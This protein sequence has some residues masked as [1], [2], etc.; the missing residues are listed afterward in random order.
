MNTTAIFEIPPMKRIGSFFLFILLMLTIALPVHA[1]GGGGAPAKSP[2]MEAI[3]GASL[4]ELPEKLTELDLD[5]DGYLSLD[6]LGVPSVVQ[7]LVGGKSPADVASYLAEFDAD[8]DGILS[9][10]EL[11][12]SQ[13]SGDV[14][15]LWLCVAY[16]LVAL[17]FSSRCSVAE[18]VLLSISPSYVANLEKE[19]KPSATHHSGFVA[20]RLMWT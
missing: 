13:G 7:K 17:L 14:R 2:L 3:E 19:G 9:T 12:G 10:A 18:A 11:G 4:E 16:A 20:P 5:T 15:D 8:K 6:E 1:S